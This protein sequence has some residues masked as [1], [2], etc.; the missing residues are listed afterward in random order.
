MP[1]S[2]DGTGSI[3]GISTFSFSD[4]IIHTGDTNTAIKFP[5]NDTIALDT[6]GSERIRIDSTGRVLIGTTNA[7]S[8]GSIDQNVV[9]GSTTNAEEVAL[10]LN[11]M[12]GTNNRRI[13]L[14]LDDD[15]GVFGL[16]STASTGVS[17][18][19]VRMATSEKLRIATD[20]K[21]GISSAIP[22]NILTVHSND[23]NQFAIKS[24]DSNADIILADSGGSARIR[25]SSTNF[26]IW[27]GGV[28]GS[29]YAQ[30]SGRRV[31]IASDGKTGINNT[32]PQKQIHI[33]TTGN[34]KIVIDPNYANNSGGSSNS[35]ANANN[36]VESILIRSSYGDNAGSSANAGHKWGIKFQGYNGN[37]FTQASQ[38]SA[39][40]YA[41]SEDTGAG[42][43]RN[44]GLAIHTSP[45]DSPHR[46]V[47]RINTDGRVTKPYQPSFH[48]TTSGGQFNSNLGVITFND[49]TTYINHNTGG[50][51]NTSNGRFTAPIA[52][53]YLIAAR[54]LTNSS[55]QSYTIY[56]IRRNGTSLGYIG[57]N[58][59]D[60]WLMESGTFVMDL[61][62]NDY[63]DCYLQQHSGHGGY[64]Y[65]SF[66]GFLIG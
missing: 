12:E 53:K 14:F 22:T 5:A 64:G 35:E 30:S 36:I 41:V 18:F 32:I 57:H 38:K 50:H 2:L 33:S 39:A 40:V 45:Y 19:V 59:S 10:T 31:T 48:V 52:G 42:Y 61:N 60:Y 58:H 43:N 47:M 28:A 62:A 7:D 25:H 9:I 55:T 3:S 1:I 49:T 4:E 51:Y 20:G 56:L 46:E 15:D 8:V 26:E 23:N 29:Y 65:A 24:G 11:V 27:T 44:V 66:S 13:K 21:V 6:S 54:M 37:D 17:P 16:D 63:I 34:Q